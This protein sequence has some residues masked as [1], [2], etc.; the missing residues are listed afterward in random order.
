MAAAFEPQ[1]ISPTSRNTATT[2]Q[3][4]KPVAFD[5]DFF[6]T[7]GSN[8]WTNGTS[9]DAVAPSTDTVQWWNRK[10]DDAWIPREG[11]ADNPFYSFSK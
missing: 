11:D 6:G 2:T 7:G 4:Q 1:A 8:P 3:P 5:D 9:A 10:V